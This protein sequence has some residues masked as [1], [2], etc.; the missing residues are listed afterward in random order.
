MSAGGSLTRRTEHQRAVRSGAT[1]R[2]HRATLM[3]AASCKN[4]SSLLS[5]FRSLSLRCFL[6]RYLHCVMTE[7]D[8]GVQS[9]ATRRRHKATC[10][11]VTSRKKDTLA[12]AIL[13]LTP[14]SQDL[15][16]SH[17]FSGACLFIQLQYCQ[18]VRLRRDYAL[19]SGELLLFRIRPRECQLDLSSVLRAIS[20][21]APIY[22]GLC[23]L[24][25]V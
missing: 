16:Y 15:P 3:T 23:R 10:A 21:A 24:G 11:E 13:S 8:R 25:G 5:P 14:M 19:K 6:R 12:S 9:G 17:L 18:H 4:T 7:H 20:Y 22:C 1:R 2:R